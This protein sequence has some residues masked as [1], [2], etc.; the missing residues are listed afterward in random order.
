MDGSALAFVEALHDAGIVLQAARRS[1]WPVDATIHVQHN[2]G[3]LTIHPEE[4]DGLRVSYT[5]DYGLNSP[6]SR[7]S[8]SVVVTP[9]S[10]ANEI[11]PCR[12]FLLEQ[13]AHELRRHGIGVNTTAKD[14]VVFGPQGPIQ[15][16]LRFA[17]EPARHKVL[18]V[19][20]DLALF[21]F[22]LRGHVVA[23]R[24]GHS[25][26]VELVSELMARLPQNQFVQRRAA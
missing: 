17:N 3:T 19:I 15:N 18:D 9:E 22:D 20:G 7:Q 25:H 10:F 21:G 5:L 12:T 23:Y 8:H 26:N 14:L 4:C 11:A 2:G 16:K 13:E 6:I 24:S 1:V